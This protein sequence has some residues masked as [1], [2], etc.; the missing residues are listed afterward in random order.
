MSSPYH[1]DDYGS[2]ESWNLEAFRLG[3]DS[4]EQREHIL[5]AFHEGNY[6][7]AEDIINERFEQGD[8]QS[9]GDIY[10][11]LWDSL[12]NLDPEERGKS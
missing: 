11:D 2:D 3:Y 1:R 7:V 5:D 10:A 12:D 8:Y 4:A 6:D 9:L